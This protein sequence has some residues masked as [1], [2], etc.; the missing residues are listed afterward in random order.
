[1]GLERFEHAS[2]DGEQLMALL[3]ELDA[4]LGAHGAGSVPYRIAIA[5]ERLWR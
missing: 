4:E 5:V 1:M 2:F 3:A